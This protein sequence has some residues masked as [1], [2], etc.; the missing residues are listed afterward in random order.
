MRFQKKYINVEIDKNTFLGFNRTFEIFF[1][2]SVGND[3]YNLTKH[4]EIQIT[5][6]T[7]IKFPNTVSDL[8]Q[9]WNTICK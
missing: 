1:K 2:V 8:I 5:D 9:K 4:N 6:T 7:E 3:I